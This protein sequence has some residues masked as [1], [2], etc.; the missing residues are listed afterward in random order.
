[1]LTIGKSIA[2]TLIYGTER[3]GCGK[4]LLGSVGATTVTF[5]LFL[6]LGV[7]VECSPAIVAA[8]SSRNEIGGEVQDRVVSFRENGEVEDLR[9]KQ[10][11]EE[12]YSDIGDFCR[13]S[14]NFLLSRT[15][16]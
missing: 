8:I 6:V 2:K 11:K 14:I 1:M 10:S 4:M 9:R 7:W 13:S 5:G 16:T 15:W 3:K 12:A